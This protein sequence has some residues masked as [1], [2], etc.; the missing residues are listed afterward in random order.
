[1]AE[2]VLVDIMPRKFGFGKFQD[3]V[4]GVPE[5]RISMG[6]VADFIAEVADDEEENEKENYY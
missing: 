4:P 6:K 2:D 5:R 1:M 3:F